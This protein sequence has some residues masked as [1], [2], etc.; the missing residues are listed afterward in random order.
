VEAAAL[1]RRIHAH[2]NE[3]VNTSWAACCNYHRSFAGFRGRELLLASICATLSKISNG[4]G[5]SAQRFY[6][7]WQLVRLR[8]PV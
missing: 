2:A 5:G 8:F 1:I 3:S 6:G 7:R 4:L